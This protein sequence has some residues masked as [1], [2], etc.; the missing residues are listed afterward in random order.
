M[1]CWKA[2]SLC[3]GILRSCPSST[4][5][6]LVLL[7]MV[8]R[9]G[10]AAQGAAV[11]VAAAARK[12]WRDPGEGTVGPGEVAERTR[13][14]QWVAWVPGGGWGEPVAKQGPSGKDGADAAGVSC[15]VAELWLPGGGQAVGRR[16]RV[17]RSP[18][19]RRRAKGAR[20]GAGLDPEPDSELG[21]HSPGRGRKAAAATAEQGACH[22]DA[23]SAAS[24]RLLLRG[25]P[26]PTPPA[27]HSSARPSPPGPPRA[28]RAPSR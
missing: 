10:P 22:G 27:R 6:Y 11:A 18:R 17:A 23:G 8:T 26:G 28:P 16:E 12:S 4:R 24:P 9:G 20:P 13:V 21:A 2:S 7:G 5:L 25:G 19:P 14:V 1:P 3:R 15:L